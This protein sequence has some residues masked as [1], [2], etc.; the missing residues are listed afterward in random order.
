[1]LSISRTHNRTIV[2]TEPTASIVPPPAGWKLFRATT[3]PVVELGLSFE[4]FGGSSFEVIPLWVPET[5]QFSAVKGNFSILDADGVA[6]LKAL[7]PDDGYPLSV[8]MGWLVYSG[9]GVAPMWTHS[10]ADWD[11]AVT[12]E[13]G[14]MLWGDQ[15]FA[16]SEETFDLT[17]SIGYGT[18]RKVM[19]FRK[20]DWDKD[21]QQYPYL[22]PRAT[23]C[24]P[25]GGISNDFGRGEIRA[26]LMVLDPRDYKFAGSIVPS[27]FYIPT[28]WCKAVA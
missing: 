18:Y 3:W 11:T 4:A 8:K 20:A 12:Y 10:E 23:V 28:Q 27:G 19:P 16:A 2:L 25:N 13:V 17:T 26:M 15:L 21:P 5:K 7:Q 22:F 6:H 9:V 24:R 1:M 14:T